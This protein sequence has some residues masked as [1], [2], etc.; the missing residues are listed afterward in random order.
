MKSHQPNGLS[1]P[2]KPRR[3]PIILSS[4]RRHC[5]LAGARNVTVPIA[6]LQSDR[7]NNSFIGRT[8]PSA[9][10]GSS[11]IAGLADVGHNVLGPKDEVVTSQWRRRGLSCRRKSVAFFLLQPTSLAQTRPP[12]HHGGLELVGL[13]QHPDCKC[14]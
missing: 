1:L 11:A 10:L 14:T 13:A 3:T 7:N 8:V 12:A 5:G 6:H 4:S 2:S 9:V